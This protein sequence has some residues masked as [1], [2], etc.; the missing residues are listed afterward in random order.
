MNKPHPKR[1]IASRPAAK[2]GKGELTVHGRDGR[3]VVAR[4]AANGRLQGSDR[5]S[6][7]S[8]KGVI[9]P[10][11][12]ET[13]KAEALRIASKHGPAVQR[14]VERV[15]FSDTVTAKERGIAERLRKKAKAFHGRAA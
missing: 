12:G 11:K 6:G 9:Q 14:I 3:I 5:R 10:L 7:S 8:G 2:S 4:D 13:R 1:K 15:D